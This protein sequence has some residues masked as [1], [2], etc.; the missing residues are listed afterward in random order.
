MT[1][2]VSIVLT[3]NTTKISSIGL[4]IPTIHQCTDTGNGNYTCTGSLNSEY[5]QFYTNYTPVQRHA[6]RELHVYRIHEWS[7]N[8]EYSQFYTHYTPVHRHTRR[9]LHMHRIHE[10]W[11]LSVLHSLHTS[12]QT[13]ETATTRARVFSVLTHQSSASKQDETYVIETTNRCKTPCLEPG[14]FC[15]LSCATPA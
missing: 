7:M 14:Y 2:V 11:V 4:D 1:E 3:L 9:E 6:R 8:G 5:S 13:N 10:W 15:F 12:V